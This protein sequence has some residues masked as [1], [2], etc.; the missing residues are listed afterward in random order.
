MGYSLN[1]DFEED[2]EL[3]ESEQT[4]SQQTLLTVIEIKD[5]IYNLWKVE[6]DLMSIMFGRF[7]PVRDGEPLETDSL[8]P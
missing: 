6:T 2:D 1:D 4:V 8:G 7:Y 5:E 3:Q